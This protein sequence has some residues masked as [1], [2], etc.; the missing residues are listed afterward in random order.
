MA[1]LVLIT[2][3]SVCGVVVVCLLNRESRWN[4]TCGSIAVILGCVLAILLYY[5]ETGMPG[6]K[7]LLLTTGLTAFLLAL[8]AVLASLL[9]GKPVRK[10]QTDIIEPRIELP[11][12]IRFEGTGLERNMVIS[13]LPVEDKPRPETKEQESI[14]KRKQGEMERLGKLMKSGEYPAAIKQAF[15][16]LRGGYPLLPDEKEKLKVILRILKEKVKP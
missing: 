11:P 5:N 2:A 4:R 12:E 1:M 13:A 15:H 10:E 8:V 3:C 7:T 6:I 16:I 9:C 14:D